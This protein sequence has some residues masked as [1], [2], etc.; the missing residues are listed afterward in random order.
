MSSLSLHHVFQTKPCFSLRCV[1]LDRHTCSLSTPRC[2]KLTKTD[3]HVCHRPDLPFFFVPPSRSTTFAL[4]SLNSSTIRSTTS[5]SK[6]P[7]MSTVS[8][9]PGSPFTT[10]VPHANFFLKSLA[11]LSS[12][13]SKPSS[14]AT[15]VTHFLPPRVSFLMV[16]P[17]EAC[18]FFL[19]PGSSFTLDFSVA[20]SAFFFASS[21][22]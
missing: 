11:A 14:P 8:G 9:W 2:S 22:F 15:L 18:L 17:G 21:R 7:W 1:A 6:S 16:T 12:F 13:T 10:L 19:P 4:G 3:P 5:S 20:S